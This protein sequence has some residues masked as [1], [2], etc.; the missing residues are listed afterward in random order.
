[1]HFIE[2]DDGDYRIYTGAL[3]A[4]Q[5]EGYVAAVVV[6]KVRGV[7]GRPLETYRDIAIAGGHR[8]LRPEEALTYA[9]DKA[10]EVVRS[11]RVAA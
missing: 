8:W 11:Q 2:K 3:E 9:L 7:P 10:R 6:S 4:P 1:M 5:G